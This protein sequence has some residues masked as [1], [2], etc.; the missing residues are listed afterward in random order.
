ME[1][2]DKKLCNKCCTEALGVC[3]KCKKAIDGEFMECFDLRF[4][5]ACLTCTWC[6]IELSMR[7]INRNSTSQ[8]K[9][10]NHVLWLLQEEALQMFEV[11][12]GDSWR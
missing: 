1:F 4:H 2:E 6:K 10:T 5:P 11:S 8:K 9:R 3:D 12:Q 7:S